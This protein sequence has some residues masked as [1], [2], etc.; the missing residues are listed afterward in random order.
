MSC[1]LLLFFDYD[2][3]SVENNLKFRYLLSKLVTLFITPHYHPIFPYEEASY[4]G[5]F[6]SYNRWHTA[7]TTALVTAALM[8]WT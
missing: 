6:I 8:K 4:F 7:T 3:V 2:K 1:Q 5:K